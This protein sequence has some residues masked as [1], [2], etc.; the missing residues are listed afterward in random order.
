[1]PSKSRGLTT[2]KRSR[3]VPSQ[4]PRRAGP[5]YVEAWTQTPR[6]PKSESLRL[7]SSLHVHNFLNHIYSSMYSS[8]NL[9]IKCGVDG[10]MLSTM[11]TKMNNIYDITSKGAIN[12]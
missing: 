2:D 6:L 1:M 4:G 8:S 9:D 10:V 12:L 11:N 7:E 3:L 5:P